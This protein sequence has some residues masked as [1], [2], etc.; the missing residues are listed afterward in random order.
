MVVIRLIELWLINK[1]DDVTQE[2]LL[3]NR[4]AP[5]GDQSC[6]LSVIDLL[7]RAHLDDLINAPFWWKQTVL[8]CST[9][10]NPRRL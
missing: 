5:G 9:L 4:L 3:D 1:L 7:T 6:R 8:L 10:V 2:W